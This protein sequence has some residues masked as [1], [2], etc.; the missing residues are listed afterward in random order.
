M[1]SGFGCFKDLRSGICLLQA[2]RLGDS[3]SGF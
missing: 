3:G 1:G 2:L